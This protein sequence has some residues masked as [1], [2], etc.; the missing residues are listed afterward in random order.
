[1]RISDWSS[2]VC[3]SDLVSARNRLN[4]C[5]VA[6]GAPFAGKGDR[7][8]F[9]VEIDAVMASPAGIRRWGAAAL[10]LAYVAA[11]R[12]DGFWERGLS[13]WDYAA[14]MIVVR[15]AGGYISEMNGKTV[16]LDSPSILASNNA[17]HSD[18]MKLLRK[19]L[20]N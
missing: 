4:E 2:D 17:I 12:F 16:S 7:P 15:E 13:P 14:G 11:G 20:S 8:L 10:V 19:P 5:L 1:M 6:T 18:L 3:S 9:L